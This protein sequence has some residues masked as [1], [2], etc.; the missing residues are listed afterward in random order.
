MKYIITIVIL[1]IVVLGIY[2]TKKRSN[3]GPNVH[4]G[5]TG[6]DG[7]EHN[8]D[9]IVQNPCDEEQEDTMNEK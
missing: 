2:M 6:V 1:G 3:Q 8:G 9:G 5:V 7:R 4:G